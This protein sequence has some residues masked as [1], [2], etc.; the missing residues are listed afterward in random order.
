MRN[1]PSKL[2]SCKKSNFPNLKPQFHEQFHSESSKSC[3]KLPPTAHQRLR[4]ATQHPANAGHTPAN[5]PSRPTFVA[6]AF[7]PCF[8]LRLLPLFPPLPL[9]LP[10][11]LFLPLPLLSFSPSVFAF[12][13]P[14]S[15]LPF[16]PCA[17]ISAFAPALPLRRRSITKIRRFHPPGNADTDSRPKAIISSPSG[18]FSPRSPGCARQRIIDARTIARLPAISPISL[19][20]PAKAR[21]TLPVCTL[22]THRNLTQVLHQHFSSSNGYFA[23]YD[24][25]H[26]HRNHPHIGAPTLSYGIIRQPRGRDAPTRTPTRNCARDRSR[27]ALSQ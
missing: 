3:T 8:H 18:R 22:S 5:H 25:A 13:P 10:A 17:L 9:V 27:K 7:A 16:A 11:L 4:R 2:V 23:C 24:A 19:A 14:S 20:C 12:A 6:S 1:T 15:P 26:D 21:G